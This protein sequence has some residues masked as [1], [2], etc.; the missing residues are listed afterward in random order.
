MELLRNQCAL[1]ETQSVHGELVEP[2]GV[3]FDR[4]RM[5]GGMQQL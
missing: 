2:A 4:L 1:P 5:N 3:P